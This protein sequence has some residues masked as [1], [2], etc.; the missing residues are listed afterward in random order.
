MTPLLGTLDR[1]IMRAVLSGVAMVAL[2]LL[3]LGTLFLLL[4]QQNDIGVGRY[5][6][7]RAMLFVL[8]S[9]PQQVWDLL[10]ISALIGALFGLGTLARG[11]ELTV[12]R[13][14][15]LSIWR[16][17]RG[18]AA[19][20]VL[21]VLLAIALGEW[22]APPLQQLARQQKAFDK[23]ADV[24]VAAY[25]DTWIRDGNLIVNVER[26]STARRH[27]GMTIYELSDNNRLQSVGRAVAAELDANGVWV[28]EQY[29]E[30]RY[31]GDT[32]KTRRVASQPLASGLS[33]EFIAIAASSPGQL[34]TMALSRMVVHLE[35]NGLDAREA[36]FAMWSRIAR[37]AAIFFAVLLALPFVFGS[38]RAA[39][40]GARVATGLVLGI[41]FFLLQRML[42]S[43]ALV[44]GGPPIL[45]AWVPT[46]L[47]A[48][49]VITFI[50][51]AR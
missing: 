41:G 8:L 31:D 6:A 13:A 47:M 50:L 49:V 45:L 29:A 9:L 17:A 43:G 25:G 23:L 18:V 37:T 51:R 27:P 34:P 10:P 21:L 19:A 26:A 14:A 32:V 15:G 3:S 5:T 44:F 1:Y 28:L 16:I 7:L 22:L 36:V 2:V 4:G 12:M 46:L 39:G 24:S 11:S 30:S 40:A 33:A 48:T 38:L 42:E 35:S 20:G